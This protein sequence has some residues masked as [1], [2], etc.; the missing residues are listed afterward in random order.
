MSY[1]FGWFLV[2]LG[3]I[4]LIIFSISVLGGETN[5]PMCLGSGM[6]LILGLILAIRNR[7]PSVAGGRFRT[8][9]KF[10]KTNPKDQ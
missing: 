3:L 8:I 6:C 10:R 4:L 7:P 9:N 5:I 2:V 1:R